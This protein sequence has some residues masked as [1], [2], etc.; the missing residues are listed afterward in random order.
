MKQTFCK[1]IFLWGILLGLCYYFGQ[2]YVTLAHAELLDSNPAP[3]EVVQGPPEEIRLEFN[4]AVSPSSTFAIYDKDF[5]TIPV[6]VQTDSQ[7][8]QLIIGRDVE[9][10]EPGIYTVQWLVISD[11]GH[12]IDGAFSFAV[13]FDNETGNDDGG[14]NHMELIAAAESTAVNLPGWFAWMMVA[15]AIIAPILVRNMTRN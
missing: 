13:A 14:N 4:E 10:S 5:R 11:D 8:S 3:G 6:I 1:T 9:I 15:I 2:P 12:P 7:N